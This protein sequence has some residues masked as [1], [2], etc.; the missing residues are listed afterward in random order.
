MEELLEK[1]YFYFSFGLLIGRTVCVCLFGAA[2]NDECKK[3]L[4]HLHTVSSNVYNTEVL[5]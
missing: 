2:I 4:P 3:P 1:V 5:S